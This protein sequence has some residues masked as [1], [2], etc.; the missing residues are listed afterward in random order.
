MSTP[1][2]FD[3]G[4][5]VAVALERAASALERQADVHEQSHALVKGEVQR[6][7]IAAEVDGIPLEMMMAQAAE[8]MRKM[9]GGLADE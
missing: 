2:I 5:R 9:T 1:N 3:I 6:S 8:F 4:E 7:N